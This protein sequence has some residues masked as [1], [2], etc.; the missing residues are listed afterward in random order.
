MES[1]DPLL[2][3]PLDPDSRR[4]TALLGKT[5]AEFI[6]MVSRKVN[7]CKPDAATLFHAYPKANTVAFYDGALTEIHA[8]RPWV[9]GAWRYGEMASYANVFPIPAFF[10]IYPERRMTRAESRYQAF[11]GLANGVYPNFWSTVEMKT[12]FGFLR[13]SAE[14]YDF[15]RTTPVKYA[16]LA[17]VQWLDSAQGR[18]ASPGRQVRA[19]PLRVALRGG[20]FRDGPQRLARAH[21]PPKQLSSSASGSARTRPAQCGPA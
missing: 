8:G 21:S 13:R 7:Q 4:L 1:T 17:R 20:L 10:N 9:H 6:E 11:Q 18:A 16:A 2:G 15:G 5:V 12:V 19:R 14:Y 3:D